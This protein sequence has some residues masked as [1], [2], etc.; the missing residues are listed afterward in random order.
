MKNI[1]LII[2]SFLCWFTSLSQN[3]IRIN[4]DPYFTTINHCLSD[5]NLTI[6]PELY[7]G[8]VL[9]SGVEFEI[10]GSSGTVLVEPNYVDCTNYT[11]TTFTTTD[12][13]I[14]FS[15]MLCNINHQREMIRLEIKVV[16]NAID[17]YNGVDFQ[18]RINLFNDREFTISPAV[19]NNFILNIDA[20]KY[21]EWPRFQDIKEE[22]SS[23]NYNIK[24]GAS[25]NFNYTRAV[26]TTQNQSPPSPEG[27]PQNYN[28][29]ITTTSSFAPFIVR[30]YPRFSSV[31]GGQNPFGSNSQNGCE[32]DGLSIRVRVFGQPTGENNLMSSITLTDVDVCDISELAVNNYTIKPVAVFGAS[33]PGYSGLLGPGQFPPMSTFRISV[34]TGSNTELFTQNF[35]TSNNEYNGPLYNL[36]NPALNISDGSIV[37]S[38]I[39]YPCNP[40]SSSGICTLF[41]DEAWSKTNLYFH[42]EI[43]R[44]TD[45]NM[46]RSHFT[47]GLDLDKDNDNLDYELNY[48]SLYYHFIAN[49]NVIDVPEDTSTGLI[50]GFEF[51]M[52]K[53]AAGTNQITISDFDDHI[54]ELDY[55]NFNGEDY[56]LDSP[57]NTIPSVTVYFDV[58]SMGN[59]GCGLYSNHI[60]QSTTVTKKLMPFTVS[61]FDLDV[62]KANPDQYFCV[63][64]NAVASDLV[65]ESIIPGNIT[66]IWNSPIGGNQLA[67]T[68]ELVDGQEYYLSEFGFVE[69]GCGF[70]Q[71]TQY[72]SA[73]RRKVVTHLL[74]T[75]S[76]NTEVCPCN[77]FQLQKGEKYVASAWVKENWDEQQ[78]TYNNATL[79]LQFFDGTVNTLSFNFKPEG[80]IIDGWQRIVGEFIVPFNANKISINLNNAVI[81]TIIG[82]PFAPVTVSSTVP[83]THYI[84]DF[85]GD[86]FEYCNRITSIVSANV[87]SGVLLG[88]D[89]IHQIETPSGVVMNVKVV[90]SAAFGVSNTGA[91]SATLLGTSPYT[92]NDLSTDASSEPVGEV[93]SAYFDD[94]RIHP[95]NGNM[96]SF[97][98]DPITQRLMAELDENNYATFYEYDKEGGLVRVKKETEKGVYTIQ[99]TRSK[100]STAD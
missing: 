61:V 87:P 89:S 92:C 19:P 70:I 8:G 31:M 6:T 21:C 32:I 67:S 90:S 2:V 93:V 78:T 10:A 43:Q 86:D 65:L 81:P 7:V 51:K 62:P 66:H 25:L 63:Q 72:D 16:N 88:V 46:P 44:V 42:N 56:N 100:S 76:Q 57:C 68:E 30:L 91:I 82:D 60:D 38:L 36:N 34:R 5:G 28:N 64:D 15:D 9:Q 74:Q 98:Y 35:S 48:G 77:S 12:H 45:W 53:D 84:F 52:Y 39:N 40:P 59:D 97:V 17:N 29:F 95:F 69:Y 94:I 18:L 23:L 41:C 55:D 96:K 22:M 79:G 50:P 11:T 14:D 58:T 27:L 3:E 1:I 33:F 99:E 20:S 49:Q 13:E 83:T 54:P 24:Y 47:A 75:C 4:G 37:V 85:L 26:Y 80:A 71:G 73:R